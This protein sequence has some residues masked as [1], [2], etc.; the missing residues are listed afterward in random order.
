M[1]FIKQLYYGN[2]LPS[3]QHFEKSGEYAKTLNEIVA[4]QDEIT[5]NLSEKEIQE[6]EKLFGLQAELLS[7][8]S[9]E[10]YIK[11]F[12]DGAR[13]MLDVVL[14]DDKNFKNIT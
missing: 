5:K 11:G 9:E 6:L 10:N 7:V 8:S 13:L 4:L 3:A 14:G 12:R 1:D 2:I